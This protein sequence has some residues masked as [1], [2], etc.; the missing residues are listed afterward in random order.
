MKKQLECGSMMALLYNVWW[1]L[2]GDGCAGR[3]GVG[4]MVVGVAGWLGKPR[5]MNRD[6]D[7][8]DDD[9]DDE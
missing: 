1:G 5:N 2:G 3:G 9:D 8:D 6:N 7:D 4:V